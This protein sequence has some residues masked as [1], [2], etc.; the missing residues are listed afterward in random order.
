MGRKDSQCW[1]LTA[2]EE[3]AVDV[4]FDRAVVGAQVDCVV[5]WLWKTSRSSKG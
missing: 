2:L 5:S 3:D 4:T 1:L